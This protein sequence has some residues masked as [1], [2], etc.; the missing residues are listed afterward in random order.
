MKSYQNWARRE[1]SLKQRLTALFFAGI[2]FLLI[3]PVL[4]TVSSNAVD[5]WLG[6]PKIP[7]TAAIRILGVLLLAAGGFLA[8]WSIETQVT[9][10]RGTPVPMMPTRKVIT[11]GP[12]AWCRN[13]MTLGTFLAYAGFCLLIGSFSAVAIVALLIGALLLYLK[14]IEEKELEARFGAEYL[15]YKRVTPFIVPRL[16]RKI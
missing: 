8:M 7:P 10:G 6:L 15:E 9:V 13:P 3:I 16:R 4:L 2:L 12:F 5:A 1:Y 14:L 11:G